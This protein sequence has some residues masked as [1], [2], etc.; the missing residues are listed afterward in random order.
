MAASVHAS[1]VTSLGTQFPLVEAEQGANTGCLAIAGI[2]GPVVSYLPK[3]PLPY[4]QKATYS[5]FTEESS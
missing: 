3:S 4:P 5:D 1:D 2:R